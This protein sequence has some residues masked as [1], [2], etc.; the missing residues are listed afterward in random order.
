MGYPVLMSI[1]NVAAA[2]SGGKQGIRLSKTRR[3]RD[4]KTVEEVE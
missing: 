4:N 2:V 1:D 3:A